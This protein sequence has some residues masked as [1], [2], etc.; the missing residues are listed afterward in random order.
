MGL[1]LQ[2]SNYY[3]LFQTIH[4]IPI[5]TNKQELANRF[6]SSTTLQNRLIRQRASNRRREPRQIFVHSAA[7]TS[8]APAQLSLW[9][10]AEQPPQALS[11]STLKPY[12]LLGEKNVTGKKFDLRK[13]TSEALFPAAWRNRSRGFVEPS[14][15]TWRRAPGGSHSEQTK[16]RR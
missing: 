10:I 1:L 5:P 6:P 16:P 2:V 3:T 9:F 11:A 4:K 8:S 13:T 15:I 7:N 14:R 12:N